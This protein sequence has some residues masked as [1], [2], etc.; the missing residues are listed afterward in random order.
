[1]IRVLD[2][3]SPSGVI[4][5]PSHDSPR[6]FHVLWAGTSHLITTGFTRS[7]NREVALYLITSNGIQRLASKLL[8]T[9]PAPLFAHFDVDTEILFVWARG[10]RTVQ[11]FEVAVHESTPTIV[12]LPS[13]EAAELQSG[14]DFLPKIDVDVRKVEVARAVRL[15]RRDVELVTFTIPRARVRSPFCILVL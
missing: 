10:E 1:M 11:C 13:F 6:S 4:E 2:P 7:A 5:G 14:L 12:P 3:R 9:S 15:A 8:D